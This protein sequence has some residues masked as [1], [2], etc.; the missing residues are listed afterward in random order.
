MQRL[1]KV[2]PLFIFLIV[3]GAGF[4]SAFNL[5]IQENLSNSIPSDRSFE[6]LRTVLKQ[7]ERTLLLS[8]D[9]Q[10]MDGDLDMIDQAG[11]ELTEALEERFHDQ[12][13][14]LTYRTDVDPLTVQ[15]F[16]LEHPFLFLE[17]EDYRELEHLLSPEKVEQALLEHR[18]T[19]AGLQGV[20][21]ARLRSQRRAA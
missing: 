1:I 18:N 16:I 20:G 21:T 12:L 11:A 19:L 2:G 14:E 7:G 5:N 6:S 13:S 3:L 8:L 17:A 9:I 15:A 10:T 4:Y